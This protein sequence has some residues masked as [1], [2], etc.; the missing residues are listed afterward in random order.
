MPIAWC[1]SHPSGIDFIFVS[2]VCEH[3]TDNGR[4]EECEGPRGRKKGKEKEKE[5]KKRKEK[6]RERKRKRKRNEERKRESE[7]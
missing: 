7:G 1:M 4:R 3:A 5:R 6:E 2:C